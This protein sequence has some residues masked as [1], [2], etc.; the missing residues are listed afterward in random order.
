MRSKI[1]ELQKKVD[2]L[3]KKLN[4]LKEKEKEMEGGVWRPEI[5]ERYFY[6]TP[7]GEIFCDW[8][9][10]LY[11]DNA[12]F[13]IGNVFK[14]K[15]EVEFAVEKLKVLAEL[16][17]FAEQKDRKWDGKNRHWDIVYESTLDR[18]QTVNW[19][20]CRTNGIHFESEEKA[21]QAIDLI[22]EDRIKK[23]YLEVEE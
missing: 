15:E 22:G 1:E 9:N 13:S 16:K 10:G 23:Y 17:V 11:A 18:V 20:S 5:G 19:L 14:T 6:I 4:E 21:Q 7:I 3:Q 8:N 2:E 12:R